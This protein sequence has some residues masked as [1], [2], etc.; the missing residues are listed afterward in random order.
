MAGSPFAA[1]PS[2]NFYTRGVFI[3]DV[4]EDGRPDAITTNG[5]D[6]TFSVLLGIGVSRFAAPRVI[7]RQADPALERQFFTIGDVDG[8]GHIDLAIATLTDDPIQPGR[9]AF[10]VSDGRGEFRA[11]SQTLSVPPGPHFIT[12]ADVNADGRADL[13]ITHSGS[14]VISVLLNK[15]GLQFEPAP[16]SPFN[17]G[18]ETFELGTADVNSDG[19]IDLIGATGPNVRVWLGD[20]SGRF[21]A[22]PGAAFRTN[23][24]AYHLAVGDINGDGSPDLVTPSFEGNAAT[25]L[26]S[27]RS[28]A[29]S[30]IS[31][32]LPLI[33]VKPRASIPRTNARDWIS[34]I[35]HVE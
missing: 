3:G 25:V 7:R 4:N 27:R 31:S 17:A 33:P 1:G 15:T 23:P 35:F 21:A 14:S 2:P 6:G 11:A 8:D 18:A 12:L 26:L 19:A 9:V 22:A 5:R 20:K 13:L 28:A 29:I 34:H 10:Y 16:G 24:G 32:E 30:T